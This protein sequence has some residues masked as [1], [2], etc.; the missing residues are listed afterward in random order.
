[1]K[2]IS[3]AVLGVVL[4]AGTAGAAAVDLTTFSVFPAT[5]AGLV[6]VAVP[7]NGATIAEDPAVAAVALYH[8][9]FA[10]GP[11]DLAL[12]FDYLVEFDG[13]DPADSFS[14]A[15]RSSDLAIEFLY[16]LLVGT[17]SLSFDLAP[18]RGSTISFEWALNWGGGDSVGS[19]AYLSN[20]AVSQQQLDPVP[21]PGTLLLLGSGLA[22]LAGRARRR[23]A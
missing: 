21:E 16:E 10:V 18:H 7:T 14:F 8:D 2:R 15:V 5:S 13:D 23:R 20:V 1:M 3:W 4:F 9:F 17:G 12:T 19:A 6:T 11:A 22:A